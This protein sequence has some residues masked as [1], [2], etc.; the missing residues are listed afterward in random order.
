M[1]AIAC[2]LLGGVAGALVPGLT[3]RLAVPEGQ[4]RRLDCR[5]GAALPGRLLGPTRCRACRTGSRTGS[6][7][8]AGW[9]WVPLGVLV[10]GGLGWALGPV[11]LLAAALPVAAAGLPLAAIDRTC[12]RLPDLLLVPALLGAVAV[13]V[14]AA[15]RDGN[16][17][18]LS[19]AGLAG[20]GC[21]AVYCLLS[22]V[23]RTGL[24]LGDA[25]L[26]GLL[27]LLLGW[28]GWPAVL[29]GLVLPYLLNAPVV[30]GLLLAGR[31]R[32]DTPLPFGPAL[33]AGAFLAIV[34]AGRRGADPGW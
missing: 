12:L 7:D 28:L 16:P 29:L 31:V 27:G 13:L 3:Y 9:L 30:L 14:G 22:L 6:R 33:L 10:F 25:K 34:I 19:R 1:L 21:A 2:A 15:V 23:P 26:S 4:P 20:L 8:P 24:G 18:A 11:P 17:A 32:R 5:C